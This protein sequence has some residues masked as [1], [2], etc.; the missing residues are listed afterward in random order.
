MSNLAHPFSPLTTPFHYTIKSQAFDENYEPASNT[1][2]TTNFANLA[3]G[4]HRKQNLQNTIAMINNR[5]NDLANWDNPQN[6]RYEVKVE[7]VSADIE[8]AGQAAHFPAI[9]M[10]KTTIIDKVANKEIAGNVGNSFSSY[11]RDYDFS[12]L[13]LKHNK[14]QQKFSTPTNYGVLHGKLFDLLLNSGSF[15]QQ[16]AKAPVFCLSV[17]SK[18]VYTQTTN[19]HPILGTEYTQ[20]SPS[21]TDDY[22]GKMGFK[23]RYFMPP[24]SVAP[25]AFYFKGDLLNEYSNLELISAIATME[26]FQKIYRPEIYNA[27]SVAGQVYQPSL[28]YEDYS[29]TNIEYDREERTQLAI[30]QGEWT[31]ENF[32]KPHRELLA[33]WADTEVL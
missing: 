7:I 10:L 28:T 2:L 21:L 9:E 14:N 30:K 20:D 8:I 24:K 13:L 23:V 25:Y 6:D 16:F 19:R 15:K 22:F 11:V 26:T 4:E 33:K 12:V 29:L 18:R 17:A 3:R 27:N 1:R 32:I 5:F 31:N